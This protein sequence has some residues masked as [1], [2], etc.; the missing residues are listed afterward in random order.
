MAY[1][2]LKENIADIEPAFS[3]LPA[4]LKPLFINMGTTD[5]TEIRNGKKFMAAAKKTVNAL[6]NNGVTIVAGTDMDFPGYSVY[7][8]L[9]LYVESGMSP[10]A[11]RVALRPR[12]WTW[13]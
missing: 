5:E 6:Y 8:E 2:S 13:W 11:A 4:P 9:E 1:R 12:P 10:A 3:T 7:R